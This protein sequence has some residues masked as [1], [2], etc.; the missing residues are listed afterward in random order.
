MNALSDWTLTNLPLYGP[1]LLLGVAY[2]GSLG[3]PFPIT[4][5]ILAAGAWSGLLAERVPMTP[6]KGEMLMLAAPSGAAV[7]EPVV[8]G[9][10]VYLVPRGAHLLVG[11]TMEE[12]GFDTKVT[13]EARDKLRAGAEALIP[14]LRDWA[15]VDQWA[16]LRPRSP[17]GLP[18]LGA[19]EEGLLVAAGQYRNGIL[20]APAI[21][22]HMRDLVLGRAEVI[23][24]FDPR[25]FAK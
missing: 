18:L 24:A 8:W 7:P 9:H 12:A 1:L 6:V 20:F 21:A 4:M 5:V 16:G 3:I 17:D 10:G 14:S 22:D 23:P 2:A 13:P 15:L 11:A 19:L 25:R